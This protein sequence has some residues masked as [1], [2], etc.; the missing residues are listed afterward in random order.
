MWHSKSLLRAL[1]AQ[2]Q[3]AGDVATHVWSFV[4]SLPT[5]LNTMGTA[6]W[7]LQG[8]KSGCGAEE[9]KFST[10]VVSNVVTSS[11]ETKAGLWWV[12][13]REGV[14]VSSK[15]GQE[16]TFYKGLQHLEDDGCFAHC[17]Q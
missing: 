1:K 11:V 14:A 5:G 7:E 9:D 3:F 17:E 16:G 4:A 12:Y 8:T 13:H 2:F 10:Q 15:W 6:F